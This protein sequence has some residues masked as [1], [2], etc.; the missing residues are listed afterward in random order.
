MN[1]SLQWK[2]LRSSGSWPD[3]RRSDGQVLAAPIKIKFERDIVRRA[4]GL[5]FG[6]REFVTHAEPLMERYDAT[7]ARFERRISERVSLAQRVGPEFL[8]ELLVMALGA[9]N[10]KAPQFRLIQPAPPLEDLRIRPCN[11]DG[12]RRPARKPAQISRHADHS[13]IRFSDRRFAETDLA[14][15]IDAGLKG[16]HLPQ[17]RRIF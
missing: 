12:R 4:V 9:G 7:L 11:I 8:A 16:Y 3:P 2:A 10:L 13:R 6:P 17:V 15:V 14:A 5:P 1:P